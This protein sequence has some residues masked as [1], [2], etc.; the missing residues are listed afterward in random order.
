MAL[1]YEALSER[2]METAIEVRL[3]LGLGFSRI[4]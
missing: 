1:E 2:I 4:C 3:R